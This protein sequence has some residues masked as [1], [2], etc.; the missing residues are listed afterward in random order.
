MTYFWN[1][2]RPSR[3]IHVNCVLPFVEGNEAERKDQA[4]AALSAIA[5]S[6]L[7]QTNADA[8]KAAVASVLPHISALGTSNTAMSSSGIV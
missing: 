3:Y 4:L 7:V 5:A 1:L 6:E 2:K 8:I